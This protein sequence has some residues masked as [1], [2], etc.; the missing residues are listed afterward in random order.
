MS[1]NRD[2]YIKKLKKKYNAPFSIYLT[3]KVGMR[4]ENH[5]TNI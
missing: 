4:K 1:R 2:K 3:F 5:E